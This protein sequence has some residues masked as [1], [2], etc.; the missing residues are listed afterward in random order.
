MDLERFGRLRRSAEGKAVPLPGVFD[1]GNDDVTLLALAFARGETIHTENSY[2]FTPK[3]IAH[4]LQSAG[5]R[6]VETWT[7]EQ[8]WFAVTLATVA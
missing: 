2:K 5:F 6:T 7:D 8:N 1:G 4:L 3:S